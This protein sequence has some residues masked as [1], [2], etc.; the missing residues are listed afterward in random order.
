MLKV[1]FVDQTDGHD[2]RRLYDKPTGGTL[3]SLT[4]IPEYLAKQGHEVF[5]CSKYE[6][7][8][9]QETIN[10][11]TYILKCGEI[12]KW[13][14]TV[15]NRNAL[16]MNFVQY[17][18]AN[19]SK[20]VWWLHDI[21]DSRY[22]PDNAFQLVDR[23]VALSRYCQR[24]YEDFYSID[25]SKFSIIPNGIDPE[26]YYPG[27]Y[28][29][30]DPHI[31]LSASALIKGY[32]AY[33]VTFESLKRH[34]PDLDIRFYNSQK[35]HGIDN[36]GSENNVLKMMGALGA[37]VYAPTNQKVMAHLMRKAWALLMPNTYPEICSNLLIQARACGLPVVASHIG[38]NPE[39][40]DKGGLLTSQ[41]APHDIHS[42]TV[43]YARRV[44]ELQQDPVLHAKLSSEAPQGIKTWDEIGQAWDTLIRSLYL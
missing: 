14:V 5:V 17:C 3:T 26:V 39:Y 40:L 13:D 16:P 15:F 34:D 27:N 11:V 19:G 20:L 37:H 4:K 36:T 42:W 7:K 35:L 9:G 32:T 43:E 28:A 33:P 23:I 10:G 25:S 24:T 22:L 2:P 12:P 6:P 29:A 18:K 21:V 31:Y 30:R 1:L 44:C 41:W 8:E 38:A